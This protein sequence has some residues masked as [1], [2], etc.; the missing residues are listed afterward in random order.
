ME[1]N[2]PDFWSRIETLMAEM[3][4]PPDHSPQT[5]TPAMAGSSQ[6]LQPT[7]SEDSGPGV[8][9]TLGDIAA[10]VGTGVY[11]AVAETANLGSDFVNLF[12]DDDNKVG[13]IMDPSGYKPETGF[14]KVAQSISQFATGF[15]GAGK[16]L[17]A[18]KLL[19]GAGKSV[20]F[21]RGMAQGA[22]ADFTAFD[23]HEERLSNLIESNPTLANPITRFLAAD[24]EDSAAEGRFKNT[25]EGMMLGVA[26]EALFVMVRGI[27]ASRSA[28]TVPEAED[29]L[30]R[31][32][33]ELEEIAAK[34]G[35]S[36]EELEQ[37]VEATVS[38]DTRA[39]AE[40]V[41]GSGAGKIEIDVHG[42]DPAEAKAALEGLAE[43]GGDA[44]AE[45]AFKSVDAETFIA[46]R[47]KSKRPEFL[48][49]YTKEEME[50]WQHF[51]TDDG[52]GFT[53]TDK[54]DII[55]VVNNSGKKGAGVDAVIEALAQGGKTLDCIGGH[56]SAYYQWFGFKEIWREAWKDKHA[57]KGWNYETYGRPDVVGY[58]YPAG[59]SR[60]RGDIRR[61]FENNRSNGDTGNRTM[62][63]GLGGGEHQQPNKAVREAVG[64]AE[65]R[66]T[67]GGTGASKRV[68]D[69]SFNHPVTIDHIKSFV[70]DAIKS[71]KSFTDLMDGKD[72]PFNMRRFLL[73]NDAERATLAEYFVGIQS[74]TLKAAGV[75]KH[76]SVYSEAAKRLADIG[77]EAPLDVLSKVKSL[78]EISEHLTRDVVEAEMTMNSLVHE[79]AEVIAER[80][81]KGASP[82]LDARLLF[83]HNAIQE[84]GTALSN[85]T[86]A[87]ARVTSLGNLSVGY[88]KAVRLVQSGKVD[89]KML[90]DAEKYAAWM[91]AAR[92]NPEAVSKLLKLTKCGTVMDVTT[93]AVINGLLSSPKTQLI[94]I[95]GNFLKTVLMPAEQIIGGTFMGDQNL[96][97]QGVET[98]VGLVKYLGESWKMAKITWKTG[99]N[100]LDASHKIAD[101]ISESSA[102][103]YERIRDTF[104]A[105][106]VKKGTPYSKDLQLTPMEELLARSASFLGP[107]M[108][109]P[110]KALGTMDEFFKQLNY[111]ANVHAKLTVEAAKHHPGDVLKMAEYI[112]RGLKETFDSTG[113][114]LDKDALRYAQESTWTQ[115]LRDGAYLNGG[116]GQGM[117]NLVNHYPPLKLVA[118]FIRTPTNLIR[119]FVAHTPVLA[120]I[121]KKFREAMAAGGERKAQA[122][123]QL[124]TGSLL[125]A[126]AIGLAAS[127]KM[128][129]GYPRDPAT[130]QAW[131]DSG[132]EPY[133]FK[134]G[135]AYISFARIDPFST[136]FG[137]AAD[138]AEY[139][140][141]WED[142]AKGN[143]VSGALAALSSNILSKSYL[144][145]ITDLIDA[146]GDQSVDSKAMQKYL[147]RSATMFVPY[148]SGLRFTRQLID[149]PLRETRSALDEILNTIP[150]ASHLLPERRSWITGKAISHNLFWGEHKDDLVANELAR[151]GDNLSIGA[152][153][154]KLKG[155]ELDGNQY[156]RLCELQGTVTINGL[157]QHERL[158]KLMQ[159]PSYDIGRRKMQDMPGDMG[160][161]RTKMV[162]DVINAYRRKA[163]EKL[164]KEDPAFRAAADQARK[165]KQAQNRGDVDSVK[166]LLTMPSK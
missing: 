79:I 150:L 18:A 51:V 101:G 158:S 164:L 8:L 58:E 76:S 64:V 147:Q 47:E 15:I 152:P 46:L 141:N 71:G 52:V 27:K 129:G 32:S 17:K 31:T 131:I 108:N 86:T 94:N 39:L 57:P 70:D 123:G 54:M 74:K 107:K 100:V 24:K 121:T 109:L 128:T 33:D 133:S 135:D 122:L 106:R 116:L 83:A 96:V 14:G 29:A 73:E 93:E 159:S 19:Q 140:R 28:K 22:I 161:P 87:S 72:I 26:G 104:L 66:E 117:S 78:N 120:P 97:R 9:G 34:S 137:I 154:K 4:D 40:A 125:W 124:A 165:I 42:V 55:G 162:E 99:N 3:P 1:N 132:I 110:G 90:Q 63:S 102:I 111:R 156:S 85:I 115:N 35:K 41:E 160:N 157:T 81:L 10:G 151:L 134:I 21:S 126:T 6:A 114:G 20:T 98:Y 82:E 153:G 145:G 163:Q 146:L 127:G 23:A 118:P 65:P 36:P 60:D 92:E 68:L 89:P 103:S 113:R 84:I 149:D 50:G 56:L 62:G 13:N 139:T 7:A 105:D 130:R 61:R 95:T 112:E 30:V 59:L 143:W 67:V 166:H 119:D 11:N 148:S 2:T 43:D 80:G 136:F 144:T 49:P 91:S 38:G 16:F 5:S 45:S 69:P 88:G 138:F 25:L 77:I 37:A 48:T 44:L 155:V 12:R 142:S 53:L 75:E